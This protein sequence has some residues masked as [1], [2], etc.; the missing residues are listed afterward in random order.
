[1]PHSPPPTYYT[2]DGPHKRGRSEDHDTP[3]YATGRLADRFQTLARISS[4]VL[5]DKGDDGEK[6]Q[7]AKRRKVADQGDEGPRQGWAR[8]GFVPRQ[9]S[10]VRN[11]D[12]CRL[13]KTK[14]RPPP[15]PL[16]VDAETDAP[17][18][19]AV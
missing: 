17:P 13:R 5:G 11:C 14:V 3:P 18:E 8:G 16:G 15:L 12:G 10:N 6:L 2:D 4:E 9:A 7:A 1:M 19:R